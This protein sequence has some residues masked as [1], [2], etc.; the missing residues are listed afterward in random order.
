MRAFSRKIFLR[1]KVRKKCKNT[2]F[3]HL[4]GLTMNLSSSI[5]SEIKEGNRRKEESNE[6]RR[7]SFYFFHLLSL[8][9]KRKK[10]EV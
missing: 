9:S 5:L 3:S 7:M 8:E 6:F 2:A 4:R 10:T 1:V